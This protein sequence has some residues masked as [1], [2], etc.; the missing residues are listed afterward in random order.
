MFSDKIK[1]FRH[2]RNLSQRAMAE[3]LNIAPQTLCN[4]ENGNTPPGP[5]SLVMLARYFG[6]TTDYLLD[7][8]EERRLFLEVGN[9]TD[10]QA[11]HIRFLADE[12]QR[13]NSLLKEQ[14]EKERKKKEAE[15]KQKKF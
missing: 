3:E 13:L 8:E 4:W 2:A 12:Y 1:A 11:R 15:K 5:D 7:L 14:E 9:L 10:E 6:C